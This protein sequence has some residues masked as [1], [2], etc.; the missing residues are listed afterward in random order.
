MPE[1]QCPIDQNYFANVCMLTQLYGENKSNLFY[2]PEGHKGLD[3]KTIGKYI[4]NRSNSAFKDSKWT[5]KWKRS[6][7]SIDEKD[8][9]IPLI[10][11]HD[12]Q[13]STNM[14]YRAR[15][16]GWGMFLNWQEEGVDWRLLYWHIESPWRSIGTFIR[17]LNLVFKPVYVKKGSPIAI[18]GNTG[19]PRSSTGPHLHYEL[20]KKVNGKWVSEDPM[21]HLT[22]GEVIYQKG[23]IYNRSYFYKGKQVSK[24]EVKLIKNN[25]LTI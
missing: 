5:G 4:F 16:F 17:S 15:Q 8:G 6:D 13:L 21:P 23:N 11:S 20:Q 9:F 24:E 14:Y 25:L 12:G 19:Y 3:F 1:L 18:A 7:R 10:A 2:G 22:F